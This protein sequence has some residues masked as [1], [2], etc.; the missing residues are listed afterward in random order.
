MSKLIDKIPGLLALILVAV[1]I[2]LVTLIYVGGNT[3]SIMD[4]AGEALTVPTFTDMLLY[5]SYALM[6]LAVLIT[7]LGAFFNYVKE[8]ISN[9]KS[10]LKT[11]IPLALFALVF[12][13][14][15][16]LGTGEKMSI[17]GYEGTENEGFWAQFTDMVIYSTYALFAAVGLTIIGS[18]IYVGLK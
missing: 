16:N 3:D 14:A 5:W 17:I 9:P 18:R 2:V 13:I 4:S 8:F 10:A 15:W 11:L 6:I 12:I 7:L 1:S